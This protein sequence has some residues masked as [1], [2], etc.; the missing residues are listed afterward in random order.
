MVVHVSDSPGCGRVPRPG[1]TGLAVRHRDRAGARSSFTHVQY[2]VPKEITWN[3]LQRSGSVECCIQHRLPGAWIDPA[4]TRWMPFPPPR[5]RARS[6]SC[7]AAAAGFVSGGN[8]SVHHRAELTCAAGKE[9]AT[10]PRGKHVWTVGRPKS[11][12]MPWKPAPPIRN[13]AADS[14]DVHE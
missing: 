6:T 3:T 14:A 2:L 13:S 7:S 12:T 1:A 4:T 9:P 5:V 10:E 8:A 11:D